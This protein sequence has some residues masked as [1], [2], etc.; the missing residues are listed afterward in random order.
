MLCFKKSKKSLRTESKRD[1]AAQNHGLEIAENEYLKGK[2]VYC[3]PI[4]EIQKDFTIMIYK[5]IPVL[6]WDIQP[7]KK[8]IFICKKKVYTDKHY[9]WRNRN[10]KNTSDVIFLMSS[11]WKCINFF[12]WLTICKHKETPSML[13]NL[14]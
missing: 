8:G 7:V 3:Y 9:Q 2:T 6:S 14:Q 10:E 11:V 1:W 5:L 13:I 12:S 4:K